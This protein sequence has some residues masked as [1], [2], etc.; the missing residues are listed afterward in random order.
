MHPILADRRRLGLYILGWV[1]VAGILVSLLAFAGASWAAAA[2]LV[3]PLVPPFALVCLSSWYICRAFPL[4]DAPLSLVLSTQGGAAALSASLWTYL[5][6]S[7]AGVLDAVFPGIE[8]L[9]GRQAPL[10]LAFGALLYLLAATLHY[11]IVALDEQQRAERHALEIKVLA[12][13]AELTALRAQLQPHFLFNSLNSISAL[14]AVDAEGARRMCLLLADFL[15]RSL[16]LGARQAIPLADE[17]SLVSAFL[18]VEKVRFG[19]RLEVDQRIDDEARPCLIP[20]LL[21]QPLVENGVNHGIA[22]TL[23]GGTITI[24]ARRHGDQLEI[25]V[26]NPCDPERPRKPGTGVGLANVRRRLEAVHGGAARVRVTEEP[27]AF[28]VEI[29]LPASVVA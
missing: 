22:H 23:G 6:R 27:T 3:V 2:A 16:T 25:A 14:T 1:P 26:A 15:R 7:W 5:A 9:V 11:V 24:E 21:L 8:P 17:L 20:P 13:E 19:S 12:R 29:K 28:R 10:F 4:Q 18:A